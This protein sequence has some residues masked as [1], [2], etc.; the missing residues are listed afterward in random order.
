MENYVDSAHL[1]AKF[2][3]AYAELIP[4]ITD[5]NQ[6]PHVDKIYHQRVRRDS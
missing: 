5:R 4:N 6:L 2:R 1:V 3:A